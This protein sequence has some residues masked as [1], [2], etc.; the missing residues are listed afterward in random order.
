VQIDRARVTGEQD[1]GGVIEPLMTADEVAAAL[2]VNRKFV[3]ARVHAGKLR[4]YKLGSQYRF[5]PEDVR[6]FVEA[7]VAAPDAAPQVR[8]RPRRVAPAGSFRA[9]LEGRAV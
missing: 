8:E 1:G 7:S 2:G 9:L 5:R 3:Y 4:G 6:A